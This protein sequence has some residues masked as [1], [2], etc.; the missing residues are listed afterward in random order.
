VFKAPKIILLIAPTRAFDRGLLQGIARYANEY[1]PWTFYREPPH[2]QAADWKQRVSDRLRGGQIDGI[3]MREPER[4]EEIIRCG[5]P[6]ICAPVTRRTVEGFINIAIDNEAVGRLG[7]EHL[8]HCGFRHFAYCG[9]GGI[10]WS[11]KRGEAF[12]KRLAEAGHSCHPYR[13]P[14]AKG[15][16][17]E[18]EEP[19]LVKWLRSLPKPV[20]IMACNDDRSQHVLDACHAA[21]I[22]V[23]SEVAIIGVDNDEFICRLANPPLS[24]ICL[25]P[26]NL[27]Y[28]AAQLL[29]RALTDKAGCDAVVEGVPTHVVARSSTNILLVED[30]EMA[31]AVRFI[32]EN[33]DQS[34]QVDDIAAAIGIS[35]RSLQHRFAHAI[36]RSVHSHILRE[37]VNRITQL[38][39]ETDLTVAQIADMLDFSSPKQLDRVFTRFQGMPPTVYRARYCI[40]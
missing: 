7:A 8:L 3:I 35:R 4:I 23:P 24:S 34:L 29:D 37:R 15:V 9:F 26:E 36:G 11:A 17:W 33:C 14:A 31:R 25:N 18:K 40:K 1:G 30:E 5:I 12:Q 13:P 39:V 2:Y 28:R 32:R 10:Y 21:R 19:L 38:L 22:H 20:G 27:G 6:G 16:L